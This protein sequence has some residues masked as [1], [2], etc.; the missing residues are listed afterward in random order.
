MASPTEQDLAAGV[1]AGA[2]IVKRVPAPS[3]QGEL[4][5]DEQG[6]VY[7]TGGTS[8]SGSYFSLRPEDRQGTR[9]F[10]D[11]IVDPKTGGYKLVSATGEGYDFGPSEHVR[12]MPKANP[13][14]SDPGYLAFVANAGMDYETAAADVARRKAAINN[15][16]GVRIPEIKKAGEKTKEGIYGDFASRGLY[17]AGQQSVR[18][19]EAEAQT[20]S[21]IGKAEA[22]AAG[23][24]EDLVGGLVGKRQQYLKDA[25]SRGYDVAGSQDLENR[26]SEVDK[27]YPLGGKT[28]LKY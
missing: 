20:L 5:I 18:E 11:I 2:N 24:I 1:P 17:G 26:L 3:G 22:S 6:G 7:D 16:L 8:F 13:L 10:K 15:A 4:L 9:T 12:N 28:G 14:Y 21:D 27:K 25:T 19:G 23:E